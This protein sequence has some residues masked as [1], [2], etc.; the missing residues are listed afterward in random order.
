MEIDVQNLK[1]IN[2]GDWVESSCL[3]GYFRVWQIK[4]C[5]RDAKDIGF[6][7]LLKKAVTPKMKFSFTTEK[8]HVAWCEKLR[9]SK[10]G[11]IE[12]ML[13]DNPA[14]KQKFEKL[15]PLFPCIQNLYFLEIEKNRIE[16]FREK[17]KGLPRYYTKEQFDSFVLQEGLQKYIRSD[18]KD[19]EHSVTL[20]IYTQ[21]WIVDRDRKMLFCNPQIGNVWGTLAKLDAQE[22][23]DFLKASKSCSGL[24]EYLYCMNVRPCIFF[25][26][27]TSDPAYYIIMI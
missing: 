13:N 12:R 17:I 6:I 11:E 4:H 26:L 5:Y 22:W 19:P 27:L 3:K 10:V 21:E 14:K 25:F 24:F 1:G 8:C 7:L 2:V 18:S 20:S 9:E 15:P 16:D 23:S